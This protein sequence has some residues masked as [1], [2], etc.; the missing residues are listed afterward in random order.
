MQ[1]SPT[2]RISLGLVCLT[3]T[4]L[5]LGK[6][7]GFAPD[8]AR[9]VFESRRIF[10]ENMAVQFSAAAERGDLNLIRSMLQTMIDRDQDVRSAAVRSSTGELLARAGNHL[11]S[12]QPPPEG[13]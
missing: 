13:R 2:I 6:S 11:A 5:L 9:V 12:W 7:M 10:V 8:W 4:V 1:L 3:V